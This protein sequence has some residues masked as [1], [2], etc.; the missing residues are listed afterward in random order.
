MYSL[1]T[2][3]QRENVRAPDGKWIYEVNIGW[4]LI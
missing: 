4:I 1:L 3:T 2:V